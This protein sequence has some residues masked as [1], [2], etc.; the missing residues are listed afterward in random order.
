MPYAAPLPDAQCA[1]IAANTKVLAE[2]STLSGTHS[3][4]G[5]LKRSVNIG[6]GV[7]SADEKLAN[8]AVRLEIAAN[9]AG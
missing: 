7:L 9:N 2:G 8:A 6:D 3:S 1:T 5:I 4:H